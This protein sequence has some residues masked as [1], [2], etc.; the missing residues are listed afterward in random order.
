MTR[1]GHAVSAVRGRGRGRDADDV[2]GHVLRGLLPRRHRRDVRPLAAAGGGGH[3]GAGA[4]AASRPCCPART[5]S[6]GG[7]AAGARF[8][9]AVLA[10]HADRH[11]R[12]PRGAALGARDHRPAHA[13][14]CSTAATT[15]RVDE[16][17]VRLAR[18]AARC[19]APGLIG[20]GRSTS[21]RTRSRSSSTTWRRSRPRCARG[22]VARVLA[23]PA[24]TN[25]GMVL[26]EPGF[27]ADAA[28]AD[29]RHGT[30]LV[31]DETHTL[32]SGLGGYTRAM[33]LEPDF[34]VLRQGRSPAALP[35]AV[36]GFRPRSQAAH[37][38]ARAR[39][40]TAGHSG[41]GTTLAGNALAIAAL[42]ASARPQLMTAAELCADGCAG[43]A[44]R[45]R[46]AA[47]ARAGVASHW[48][49]SR[50][51]A[52]LEFGFCRAP[53]RNGSE[54]EAAMRPQL[55]GGTAS[56]PAQSR[57]ADHAVPQ[58]DAAPAPAT[59]EAQVDAC[60]RA[61]GEC[62]DAT[63]GGGA[64]EPLTR[65][66]P[67]RPKLRELPQPPPRRSMRCSSSSPTLPAWRAARAC[68][69]RAASVSTESG[70]HV[71][72][73]ILGLD[74]TGEDVEATGLVWDERR[75]GSG[76]PA[77]ARARCVPRPGWHARPAQLMLT[78]HRARRHARPLADPRHA[79]A[80]VVGSARGRCGLHAGV[81]LR[82]RVLPAATSRAT[83]AG[84]AAGPAGRWHAASSANDRRL[85]P[86]RLDDLAPLFDDVYAAARA[87]GPAGA[88]TLM[89]EYAPGQFEI[90]LEHR[91]DA[92]RAVDEADRFQARW[93]AASRHATAR[94]ATFMAK[95][96]AALAGSGMHLHVS[97]ADAEGRNVFAERGPGRQPLLRHAIGGLQ[98]D[99]GREPAGV[100]APNANSYRRFRSQ[101]Y[102]PVRADLGHQQP[103]GRPARSCRAAPSR[104]TLS[105]AS[106]APTPIP[107]SRPPR[108]WPAPRTVS[109][110]GL[111]PGP[112]VAGNGYAQAH[113]AAERLPATWHEAIERAARVGI[114]RR[115]RSAPTSC[116]SC[117][118]SSARS[119]SAFP[120][121]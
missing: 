58:H 34:L 95:P 7:R 43:G 20:A 81:R 63:R 22:D 96:F 12:Q 120:P 31:I 70:R 57:H 74:V 67:R 118:R 90:T 97:L 55:R 69:R 106:A 45:G 37:A 19:I 36:Y 49:V 33:G 91:A 72:G 47:C 64:H 115:L 48:H 11:R 28:R 79:L 61:L 21:R 10:D 65:S 66:P 100:F 25:F 119:A 116:G 84:A 117:S 105:T 4:R 88:S 86:A 24:M 98:R 44:A 8:R 73:S 38:R 68:A 87:A 50:I 114:P 54:A 104:G 2:D 83:G 27:L 82:A 92:L 1:L 51:G 40:A 53:P 99:D 113:A 3:R 23:E 77:G 75:R 85:R 14:W 76:L 59:T 52:R 15:A 60:S 26:P 112:P 109:R 41:M 108:C 71:A 16:T 56:V 107:T 103:L 5:R 9:P 78:M 6:C 93:C 39:A 18:A 35:C 94:I 29:A 80:R 32:S 42:H 121:R 101:S 13:C 46:T 102:A 30:L 110:H 62:L 111:D 89:S 17:M